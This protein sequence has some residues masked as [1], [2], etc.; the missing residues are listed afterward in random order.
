LTDRFPG[1]SLAIIEKES[2]VAGHQT[3]HNSGVIHSGIYYKPGSLKA[4]LCIEGGAALLR[5]C[6]ENAVPYEICGKVIAATCESELPRLEELYR[7]GVQNR[8][9]GL[10]MLTAEEI[11]EFEPYAAGIRGI[12]VP[13]T[14]KARRAEQTGGPAHAGC[15][16]D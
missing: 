11:K 7:R 13:G 12:H 10:R 5:F 14:G 16:G 9:A 6:E 4:S 1:I 2:V 15:G 3:G 8:L